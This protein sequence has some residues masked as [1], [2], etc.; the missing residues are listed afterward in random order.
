VFVSCTDRRLFQNLE[1]SV[2]CWHP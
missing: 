1:F 2:T